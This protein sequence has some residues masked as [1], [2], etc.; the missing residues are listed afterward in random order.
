[1]PVAERISERCLALPM[2]PELTDAQVRA[3]ADA[4]RQAITTG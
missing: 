3:V 2:Y 4:L 1:L